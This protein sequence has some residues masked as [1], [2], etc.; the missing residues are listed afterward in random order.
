MLLL[1]MLLLL[2][3]VAPAVVGWRWRREGL[4]I[5][6]VAAE[7]EAKEV[8][9][10]SWCC[11]RAALSSRGEEEEEGKRG[12]RFGACSERRTPC[13]LTLW[14]S[15]RAGERQ[16]DEEEDEVEEPPEACVYAAFPEAE[17]ERRRCCSL[18]GCRS[19]TPVR[20]TGEG[21]SRMPSAVGIEI[22]GVPG[23]AAPPPAG[24]GAA[25]LFSRGK[26]GEAGLADMK[27]EEASFLPTP[28]MVLLLP[29]WPSF[30]S[31]FAASMKRRVK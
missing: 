23:G 3:P 24:V 5:A 25:K 29:S 20:K 10:S 22:V 13:L 18:G 12:A 7:E 30:P 4:C 14:G 16:E 9:C 15:K 21:N 6:G 26:T 27:E 8:W 1:P 19:L 28:C 17:E 11:F 31:S 2:L